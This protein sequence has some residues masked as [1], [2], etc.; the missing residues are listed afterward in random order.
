M[1]FDSNGNWSSDFYPVQDRDNSIPILAQKF[2][3]L[4][5]DDLKGSFEN[6]ITRDGS[7]K[8]T[9][10]INWNGHKLVNL[11]PGESATDAMNIRQSQRAQFVYA[12]DT[13]GSGEQIIVNLS[14]AITEYVPG[15]R[16][17]FKAAHTNSSSEVSFDANQAGVCRVR[18]N[19]EDELVSGAIRAGVMYEAIY[20]ETGNTQESVYKGRRM[21]II[22]QAVNL[23]EVLNTSQVTN[24]IL[25]A[26]NGVATQSG[27]TVTSGKDITLLIPNGANSDGTIKNTRYVTPAQAQYVFLDN[28]PDGVYYLFVNGENALSVSL[29]NSMQVG[30]C[31]IGQCVLSGGIITK[32]SAYSPLEVM[33]VR[34]YLNDQSERIALIAPAYNSRISKTKD[35][36][37]TAESSGWL[38]GLCYQGPNDNSRMFMTIDSA[39]FKLFSAGE[40]W[41]QYRIPFSFFVRKGSVYKLSGSTF[42]EYFYFIP[43]E[44]EIQ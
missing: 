6:C 35:T 21:Q 12:E 16:F 24:C 7:G 32:F 41:G 4:I 26:P 8:P 31:I 11:A 30:K 20:S 42:F 1:A 10:D 17:I 25:S 37:Y 44:G 14:P 13:G 2:Q 22:G 36:Q 9:Q 19:G 23:A 5:Q 33:S 27:L 39:E 34:K 38:F 15:Q 18:M 40:G 43:C 3:E 28:T 29:D